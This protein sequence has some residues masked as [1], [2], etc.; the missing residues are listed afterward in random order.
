LGPLGIYWRC[1]S[2]RNAV[3]TCILVLKLFEADRC[4][5]LCLQGRCAWR[6]SGA[7]SRRAA[8]ARVR[9]TCLLVGTGAAKTTATQTATRTGALFSFTN[10]IGHVASRNWHNA[11]LLFCAVPFARFSSSW[12]FLSQLHDLKSCCYSHHADRVTCPQHLHTEHWRRG[13]Q[14]RVAMVFRA[15]L[16]DN[17]VNVQLWRGLHQEHRMS[18][19]A[20][21]LKLQELDQLQ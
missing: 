14:Q 20:V 8:R 21:K 18:L 1:R 12:V 16:C 19:A 4:G 9:S 10:S 6:P 7:E 2:S 11:L 17:R 5:V 13:L 15:V 3:N